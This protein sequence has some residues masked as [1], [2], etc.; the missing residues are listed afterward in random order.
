LRGREKLLAVG[1]KH[2]VTTRIVESL[3]SLI[4]Y[5]FE[6]NERGERFDRIWIKIDR[7]LVGGGGLLGVF[8]L[9]VNLALQVKG[10]GSRDDLGIGLVRL[11][12]VLQGPGRLVLTKGAAR[13]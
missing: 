2:R 8:Q 12:Q 6:I 7:F 1:S 5:D 13:E 3:R 9:L 10:G 11:V 4:G